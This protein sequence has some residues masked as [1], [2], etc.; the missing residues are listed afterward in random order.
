[1]R[2]AQVGYAMNNAWLPGKQRRGQDRQGGIFRAAHLDRTRERMATVN[3]D[4]I[5]TWQ[6][7]IVVYLNNRFPNK[8][9]GNFFPPIWKKALRSGLARLP[10]PAFR[11]GAGALAHDQSAPALTRR[12]VR[13]QKARLPD[14]VEPRAKACVDLA[15]RCRED[16]QQ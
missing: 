6:R 7:G 10:R 1:M 12:P 3:E 8:C 16:S 14:H 15:P 4:L 5:H 2:I 9:R 13:R 11:P